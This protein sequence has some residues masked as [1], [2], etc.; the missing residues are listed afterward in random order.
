VLEGL[1]HSEKDPQKKIS[2]LEKS[3]EKQE[4]LVSSL[5]N[6]SQAHHEDVATKNKSYVE[7]TA[8]VDKD[9][10]C[11]ERLKQDEAK[12]DLS[13]HRF[14][15]TAAAYES[16]TEA[17]KKQM[18]G[19]FWAIKDQ[20]DADTNALIQTQEDCAPKGVQIPPTLPPSN[21]VPVTKGTCR[22]LWC[23]SWRNATCNAD[24]M[25]AC[26]P[27]TCAS[28]DG[29]SCVPRGSPV[30]LASPSTEM[31][32]EPAA[33]S[34]VFLAAAALMMTAFLVVRRRR[35]SE[36]QMPDSVLG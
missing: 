4:A 8:T 7:I 3:V 13:T 22:F 16:A 5:A 26:S 17:D 20:K 29:E 34:T 31:P 10:K 35:A 11:I 33:A 25:C 28:S 23:K 15:L 36:I 24:Y 32:A 19:A 14:N 27:G 2:L 6:Q 9:T 21:C 18:F 30:F 1:E 12:L